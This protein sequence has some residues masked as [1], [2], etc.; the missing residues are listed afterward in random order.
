MAA[1]DCLAAGVE[2]LHRAPDDVF[3]HGAV[4]F[5]GQF[6]EAGVDAK[7]PGFPSE[8][9]WIDRGAMPAESG[10]GEEGGEAEGLRGGGAD[11]LPNVDV[12]AI[13]DDFQCIDEADIDGTVDVCRSIVSFAT[14]VDVWELFFHATALGYGLFEGLEPKHGGKSQSGSES[15][16][17]ARV[18][19]RRQCSRKNEQQKEACWDR[20]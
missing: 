18:N 9:K 13:G 12:H 15:L 17:C 10:A 6:D 19:R 11:D 1:F 7:F 20:P 16:T 8:V 3:G 5:P 14:W 4:D 2:R